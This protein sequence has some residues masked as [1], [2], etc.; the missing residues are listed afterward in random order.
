M[1]SLSTALTEDA[2]S[3]DRRQAL[4]IL[5]NLCIPTENKAAILFGEPAEHLITALLNVLRHRMAESYLAAVTLL[6]L[7]YLQD[8]HAKNMLFT[9]IPIPDGNED[10]SAT[11][12][13]QQPVDHPLSLIRTLEAV[14]KDFYVYVP[15]KDVHSVEKQCV[16]WCM[17]VVQNLVS[18]VQDNAFVVGTKTIIPAIAA[19]CLSHADTSN[20]S[21]WTRDSVE[22]A[23]LMLLVHVCRIDECLEAM[24][25]NHRVVDQVVTVCE[26]LESSAEGIH[27]TRASALLERFG[28]SS[29][30]VGYSV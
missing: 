29:R 21:H 8:D 9:Y 24:K 22:D 2:S 5:N 12:S 15:Q 28:G 14:M 1:Q 16:R 3:A 30:S 20:L 11:Y 10:A 19:A 23:S 6:N 17:N 7:S 26:Q 27:Q 4:L 18:T 13:Y 25:Q